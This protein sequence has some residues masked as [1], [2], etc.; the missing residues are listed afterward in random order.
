MLHIGMTGVEWTH[1]RASLPQRSQELHKSLFI[2]E[3]IFL[4]NHWDIQ[5]TMQYD[6]KLD[7]CVMALCHFGNYKHC[8][9]VD[10]TSLHDD[11]S[12]ITATSH[13]LEYCITYYEK[14]YIFRTAMSKFCWLGN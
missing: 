2:P 13:G 11:V 3:R 10:G 9:S 1:G 5:L 14:A 12:G 4:R 6:L 7:L 8:Q